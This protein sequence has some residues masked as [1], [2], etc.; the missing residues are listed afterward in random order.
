MI[1]DLMTEFDFPQDA[2]RT[3][4]AAY[5]RLSGDPVTGAL[6]ARAEEA[7]YRRDDPDFPV[8]LD[9]LAE[10]GGICSY[11]SDLVLWLLCTRSLRDVYRARG[12]P[13]QMWRNVGTDLRC[14]LMEC[15]T[16]YGVWGT[17]TR[18]FRDFYLLERFAFRRLE[19]DVFQWNDGNCRGLVSDGDTAYSCH[20]P[21]SGPLLPEL[22]MQSLRELHAF[23]GDGLRNGILPVKC[24]SWL[25]YPPI[26]ALCPERSN[27]RRF[28][29]LFR[30]T[31]IVEHKNPY[32]DFW[33]IFHL[34]YTGP[35][36][37]E[38]APE[39]TALRRS[40]KRYL[41]DGGGIGCGVGYLLFDGE[42]IL[43]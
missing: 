1:H 24:C 40:L 21:S 38:Q 16:V 10:A 17:F 15:R 37:L 32:Q 29:E 6:L 22:V 36:S 26:V 9:R 2:V 34:Q 19:F 28:A 8:C 43:G 30:I 12:I 4:D 11:T 7:V 33:R 23:A 31:G 20:I 35:E 27:I 14:K 5:E 42:K 41:L 3:L 18:W 25:L 39:D 13:E